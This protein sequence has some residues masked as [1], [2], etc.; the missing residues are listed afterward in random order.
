L[1][2]LLRI[3][4]YTENWATE[5]TKLK[6]HLNSILDPFQIEILHVGSTSVPGMYAKPILDIDIVYQENFDKIKSILTS[7]N[8]RYRG[9]LGIENRYSFK[10]L[11][12][13][14]HEHHLYVVLDNCEALN[15]HLNLKIA[16][17]KSK[18]NREEYSQ[19][20][21]D[22]ISKNNKDRDLYTESKTTLINRIILEDKL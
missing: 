1:S 10:Y 8:Y 2:K 21:R 11:K 5:F 13:D 6:D 17:L 19:L 3:E 15:N 16:L 9:D 12:D 7:N 18:K 14:Y 20:K 4:K 22:L